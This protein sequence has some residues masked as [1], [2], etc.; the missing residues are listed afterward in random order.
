MARTTV[1][2]VQ[3]IISTSLATAQVQAF[4]DDASL[5]VDTFLEGACTAL[6]ATILTTVEKYLAAH[7]ITARDPS[8]T[9]AKWDK[10]SETYQ[11]DGKTSEYLRAAIALD[12]CG[13][14]SEKFLEQEKKRPVKFRMG[15]GFDDNLDLPTD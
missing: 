14:V 9:S 15:E 10:V 13:I 5:W 4:I 6:T 7:M 12:P 2:D 3:A 1:S 8:L 11:R